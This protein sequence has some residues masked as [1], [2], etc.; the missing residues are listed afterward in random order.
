MINYNDND[1]MPSQELVE[2]HQLTAPLFASDHKVLS[3]KQ[4]M[5]ELYDRENDFENWND[6]MLQF[7]TTPASFW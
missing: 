5:N 6:Y 7:D 2:G 3:V 1:I 4:Q